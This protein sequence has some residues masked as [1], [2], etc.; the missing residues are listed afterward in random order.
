VK[1]IE[2]AFLLEPVTV[3]LAKLLPSRPVTDEARASVRYRKIAASI[4]E[5]GIIEAPIVFPSKDEKGGYVILDGH[6][7]IDVLRQMKVGDVVCLVS[8]DDED[9][10]Y[11]H[12]VNR[13]AP[14]QEARMLRRAI[15]NG[16]SETRLARA[17]NL[18]VDTLRD[19]QAR[20]DGICPE[21]LEILK[22][23]PIT[24]SALRVLKK[25][26]PLRQISMAE[27]MHA[28]ATYSSSYAHALLLGTP[29]EQLVE[30]AKKP[31]PARPEDLAKMERELAGLERDFALVSE[32]YAKNTFDLTLARAYLKKLL[33]NA[34]VGRY[35]AKKHAEVLREFQTMI[36]AG[37][38]D[39]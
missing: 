39:G 26:K 6:L 7:R 21:A 32:T 38:L 35:L 22:D 16:A 13:L 10:T 8:K 34:R 33:E 3:P 1:R 23:K 36:E 9:C 25:V 18:T 37:T 11:N 31:T 24:E 29:N 5:V 17:L 2:N 30:G 28:T 4:P 14:I 15:A 20:L 27:M 19:T 12:R